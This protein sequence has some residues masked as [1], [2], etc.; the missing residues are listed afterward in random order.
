MPYFEQFTA[1]V[2]QD[3]MGRPPRLSGMYSSGN[4]TAWETEFGP[5]FWPGFNKRAFQARP[6]CSARPSGMKMC[7]L[8]GNQD[9]SNFKASHVYVMPRSMVPSYAGN[10]D[11]PIIVGNTLASQGH[12]SAESNF[13]LFGNVLI[14]LNPEIKPDE[15]DLMI[16][17]HIKL[18]QYVIDAH[19]PD[20]D[21]RARQ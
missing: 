4:A 3:L 15:I 20:Y 9:P 1:R 16:P 19:V 13:K 2:Y 14:K 8:N 17:Y 7:L 12:V 5:G 6:N 10:N 21:W 18:I 11:I